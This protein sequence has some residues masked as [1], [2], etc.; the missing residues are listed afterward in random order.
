[1]PAALL[2]QADVT[3]PANDDD[4]TGT[5]NFPDNTAN[6]G[7]EADTNTDNNTI[8]E[9]NGPDRSLS[10]FNGIE[11]GSSYNAVKDY[12]R[13]LS[14]SEDTD[15]K[16]E[17]VRDVPEKEILIERKGIE[18][19][20]VFYKKPEMS[21]EKQRS[22]IDIVPVD[23]DNTNEENNPEGNEE[24]RPDNENNNADNNEENTGPTEKERRTP[25]LFFVHTHF[26]MLPTDQLYEKVK[27][28]YGERTGRRMNDDEDR[29]AYLWDLKE[30]YLVQWVE[31]FEEQ[32]YTRDLTYV[33]KE[34]REEI[35]KDLREYQY[36]RE[37]KALDG[38]LP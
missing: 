12:F 33:S 11:W 6:P 34:I 30:G 35:K 36:H 38:I 25:R 26:T 14:E 32:I 2:S 15:V 24:A 13:R 9:E 3:Q 28:K 19:R 17:I 18:Y 23:E 20:Y 16:I 21:D 37:L 7:T 29:G 4:G 8:N 22:D 5:D 27:Q 31:P 1:M 10:G